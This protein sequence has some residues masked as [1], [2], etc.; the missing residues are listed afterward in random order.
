MRFKWSFGTEVFLCLMLLCNF[1]FHQGTIESITPASISGLRKVLNTSMMDIMYYT[2]PFYRY[3]VRG[4]LPVS[5]LRGLKG[6]GLI[7]SK[8][9]LQ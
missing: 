7:E 6:Q 8:L 1:H 3:E 9:T 2:S 4:T 5:P